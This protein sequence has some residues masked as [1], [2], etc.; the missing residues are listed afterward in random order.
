MQ[1]AEAAPRDDMR[2]GRDRTV[3]QEDFGARQLDRLKA[4]DA[5]GN[6]EL[7]TAELEDMVLKQMV[8]RRAQRMTKRLDA[9][10][11]GTV[12]LAE[13][14]DRQAKRFAFLDR[15]GDG[16]L[17]RSEMRR[18]HGGHKNGSHRQHG[19]RGHDAR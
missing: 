5:D 16:K 14:E 3:A 8:E 13:V 9:N 1:N 18:G 15:N 7:S 2:K 17:E 6:G 11:D 12:T 4:A 10:G 19:P